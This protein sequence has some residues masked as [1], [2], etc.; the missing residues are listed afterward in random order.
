MVHYDDCSFTASVRIATRGVL[1]GLPLL[2]LSI[3]RTPYAG[4]ETDRTVELCNRL[5]AASY[6]YRNPYPAV[7][8]D[9]LMG[10]SLK[11]LQ[12]ESTCRKALENDKGNLQTKF[13]LAR[14]LILAGKSNEGEKL[15]IEAAESGYGA[16]SLLL[17]HSYYKGW[18]D[19][20]NKSKAVKWFSI[21]A[22]HGNA[23]AQLVLGAM[24]HSGDGVDSDQE[25]AYQLLDASARQ[26]NAGAQ[27]LLGAMYYE[28]TFVD[29]DLAKAFELFK[30]SADQGLVHAQYTTGL[31][32]LDGEGTKKNS[33]AGLAL[34]TKAAEN[35][36]PL[37][38]SK[39]GSI[40]FEGKLVE[41]NKD[42]S[43]RLFCL[44][45]AFG[46]E[47]YFALSGEELICPD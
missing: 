11:N 14:I 30:A 45:G 27:F 13:Q 10:Q 9:S 15:A 4:A 44:A 3:A 31:M 12:A 34:L 20:P 25:K 1:V 18:I 22:E 19:K 36:Y 39:L 33:P 32:Y 5:A 40:Y 28:G 29:R 24:Y 43:R 7:S 6:D 35:N 26:G 23:D 37:A 8:D 47:S 46:K 16:A 21:A 38:Q 41:M 42:K 2:I 17:G